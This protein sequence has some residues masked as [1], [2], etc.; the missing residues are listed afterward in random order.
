MRVAATGL[1]PV[2]WLISSSVETAGAFGVTLPA[3]FGNDYSGVVDEVGDGVEGFALGD[4]VYGG[5]RGR[6]AAEY[7]VANV[8]REALRHTP[9]QVDDVT[10]STLL[11]AGR[12]A[13]AALTSIGVG[14]GDTVLIGGAAG[15]VGVFAVQLARQ[16]GARVI[17]TAA[18]ESAEFLRSLGAEPVTYGPGLAGRVREAA[19]GGITAA[20][21]LFGTETAYAALELGVPAERISTIAAHDPQLNAKAVG[22]ADASPDALER[23]TALIAAGKLRVPIARIFALADIR[24]AVD[25]QRGGHVNGKVVVTVP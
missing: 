22:G 10:A 11:I 15:G 4:R 20:T 24:R 16:A 8:G 5:A 14:P 13:E 3:G 21:D 25:L 18:A 17:G 9:D 1:N 2:D 7:V 23:I 12:T 6:A 19:P